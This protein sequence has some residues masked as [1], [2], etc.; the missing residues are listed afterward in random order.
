MR[1]STVRHLLGQIL[2]LVALI[3]AVTLAPIRPAF[4]Q[5]AASSW[6]YTGS[7]NT[8]RAWHS[9]TLLPNGKVLVVGGSSG[10]E[11]PSRNYRVVRSINRDVERYWQPKRAPIGLHDDAARKRQSARRRGIRQEW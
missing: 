6:S 11:R 7:L 3:S 8:A 1:V 2:A 5:E 4:T 10:S 9:A